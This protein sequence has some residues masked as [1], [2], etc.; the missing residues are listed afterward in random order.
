M[1]AMIKSANADSAYKDR[2]TAIKITSN[3]KG[4]I[5]IE[6]VFSIHN[7]NDIIISNNPC[8]ITDMYTLSLLNDRSI[9]F[10]YQDDEF[11]IT[12]DTDVILAHT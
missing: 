10:S 4:G 1:K 6:Y 5:E 2:C 9:D 11:I 8:V 3:S 12:R 7:T